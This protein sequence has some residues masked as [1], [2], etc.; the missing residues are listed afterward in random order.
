MDVII[1]KAESRDIPDLIALNDEFNGVGSTIMSMEEA[2]KA[3][4]EIVIVA[5]VAGK[6]VGFI[7]GLYWRSICYADGFQGIITE[8]FVNEN[9]RRNGIA[10]KI[11]AG[12][13]DEFVCL[14]VRE[15]TLAT[16]L[17]NYV[18]RKFYESCGY[19][20]REEMVYDKTL[21]SE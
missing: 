9:Y 18:G 1:R 3:D 6:V 8:L 16:P 14:N 13:E 21:F 10:A 17:D 5:V 4:N 7:C 12:L 20:D 2:L 19:N 11:I 15:I